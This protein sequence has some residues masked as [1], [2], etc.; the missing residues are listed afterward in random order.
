[1]QYFDGKHKK[2]VGCSDDMMKGEKGICRS[3]PRKDE[4]E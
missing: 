3:L 4:T 1:V 2:Q